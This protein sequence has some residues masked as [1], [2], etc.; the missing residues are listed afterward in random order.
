MAFIIRKKWK[1]FELV[2]NRRINGIHKRRLLYYMGTK[3]IIPS[4]ILGKFKISDDNLARLKL[5]HQY[6][7]I[8]NDKI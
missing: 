5:K 7:T 2:E 6:L 1:Y 8:T 4:S 3:L